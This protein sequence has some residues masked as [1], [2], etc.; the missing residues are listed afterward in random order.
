MTVNELRE[1]LKEL[2]GDL[3]VYVNVNP[4]CSSLMSPQGVHTNC[5]DCFLFSIPEWRTLIGH[6]GPGSLKQL[7]EEWEEFMQEHPE[8]YPPLPMDPTDEAEIKAAKAE[9]QAWEATAEKKSARPKSKPRTGKA[10]K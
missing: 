6:S 2:P 5:G 8:Q 10:R 9:F 7:K 1:A 4:D 3:E